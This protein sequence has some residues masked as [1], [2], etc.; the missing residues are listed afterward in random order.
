MIP[1]KSRK[2]WVV[3]K[4]EETVVPVIKSNNHVSSE[5]L[6]LNIFVYVMTRTTIKKGKSY[7]IRVSVEQW[8]LLIVMHLGLGREYS[9]LKR[10]ALHNL[11]F[12][13]LKVC[14]K[15]GRKSPVRCFSRLAN[16]SQK[17]GNLLLCFLNAG[18]FYSSFS[19]II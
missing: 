12:H 18:D 17:S 19:P 7:T 1:T 8:R 14:R 16:I 10:L 2:K 5:L 13:Y 3:G 6:D 15:Y 11:N 9:T 4:K